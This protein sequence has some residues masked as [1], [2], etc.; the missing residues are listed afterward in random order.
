[1][2]EGHKSGKISATIL[3]K[4]KY[5]TNPSVTSE[6]RVMATSGKLTA[7]L[8]GRMAT[9]LSETYLHQLYQLGTIIK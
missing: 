5:I 4:H 8:K 9:H 6:D 2:D 3:Y 7:E 1:M